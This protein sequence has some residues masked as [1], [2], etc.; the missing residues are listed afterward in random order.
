[1]T[2]PDLSTV[3][4]LSSL[5][6]RLRCPNCT[7]DL[8]STGEG[9]R[10]DG[11]E[12][13]YPFRRGIPLLAIHGTTETWTGDMLPE[14]SAAYQEEYEELSEARR[15]NE[16]YR[17]QVTKRWS[18]RREFQ[19]LDGLLS[20]QPRSELLLDLP[21]GGGRLSDRLAPFTER[22]VEADIAFGQLRYALEHHEGTDPRIW[23]S[24]SAFHIPFHDASVDGVVCCRLSHHLPTPEERERLVRELLRVAERFVIMTFFDYHS[25]KNYIRRARRPFNGKP[26]KMTMTVERVRELA[27]E[28]GA[29]LVAAPPLSRLFSG[30]R[31]ALLEKR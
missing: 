16:E 22:L 29:R 26:P 2:P 18:T 25:V 31:Y 5:D 4:D 9:L 14:T 7:G 10:C 23:M 28:G 13:F 12:A 11:C 15:Y 8:D 3:Q 30:H 27:E 1:M 6:G 21:C 19:L 24:A 17:D 20:S